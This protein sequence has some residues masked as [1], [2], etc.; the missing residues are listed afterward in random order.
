MN[1]IMLRGTGPKASN[2]G[3]WM[4]GCT[5][6]SAMETSKRIWLKVEGS[7]ISY[8]LLLFYTNI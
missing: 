8:C 2:S 6:T 4:C 7:S 3:G 5:I 1:D